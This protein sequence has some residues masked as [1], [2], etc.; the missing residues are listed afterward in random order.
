MPH[1]LLAAAL[2]ADA[3]SAA[4][5]LPRWVDDVLTHGEWVGTQA[6]RR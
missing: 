4:A 2:V 6:Q 1:S 3:A 5:L